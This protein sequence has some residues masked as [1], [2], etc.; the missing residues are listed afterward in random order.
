MDDIEKIVEKKARQFIEKKDE[1]NVNSLIDNK[2]KEVS[3]VKSAIDLFATQTALKQEGTLEKVVGEKEE[4]LR[5]DAEA[6]RIQAET[7]KIEKEI[8]KVV[9]EKEK[10][11]AEYD[12]EIL[13]KQKEVERLKAEGDRAQ[14]FF[15]SNK[16]VLKH[17]GIRE[18]KSL[19]TMQVLIVPATIIFII[20]QIL[21]FPI[22]FCGLVL[23]AVINIVGNVCG[24]IKYQALKIIVTIFLLIIVVVVSFCCYYFSGKYFVK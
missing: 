7:E 17:L 8:K 24:A 14:A 1:S 6:K 10:Q 4:E 18:K 23:E 5:N 9:Q 11:L 13:A 21:L 16:E 15:D 20:V 19:K 3:D 2:I 12:K 22:T